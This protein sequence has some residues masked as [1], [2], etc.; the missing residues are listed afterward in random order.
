MN[1]H[2]SVTISPAPAVVAAFSIYWVSK[3]CPPTMSPRCC[4]L[5]SCYHFRSW[6]RASHPATPLA[7]LWCILEAKS[8]KNG[9]ILLKF[10]TKILSNAVRGALQEMVQPQTNN[11]RVNT[12][13]QHTIL[14]YTGSISA[15]L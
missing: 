1:F 10:S 3:C 15:A 8:G 14:F 4:Q 7:Y 13:L 9:N 2:I 6:T 5:G 12:N 11:F